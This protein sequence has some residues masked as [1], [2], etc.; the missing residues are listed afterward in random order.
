MLLMPPILSCGLLDLFSK[1]EGWFL[2]CVIVSCCLDL[3]LFGPLTA[4]EVGAWPYSVGI[5]VKWVAFLGT[6]HWS[7]DRA[8]LWVGG[9]SCVEML[10]FIS[11]GLVRGLFWRM[12]FLGI[13]DRDA[14]FQCRLFLWVQALIFGAHAVS[15]VL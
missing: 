4:E 5:L 2:L 8:D 15:L 12:F 10:L 13:G 14:Q 7:A 6:S 11:Y 3:R 1:G 9:V